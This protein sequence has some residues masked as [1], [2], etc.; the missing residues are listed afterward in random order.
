MRRLRNHWRHHWRFY[1]AALLGAV[2][3]AVL[4]G[5]GFSIRILAAGNSSFALYLLLMAIVVAQTT[6]KDLKQRSALEDEGIAI[7][8]LVALAIIVLSSIAIFTALRQK[9]GPSPLA[10][11]LALAGIPLGWFALHTLIAFH[12]A[13]IYYG[14]NGSQKQ[15]GLDFPQTEEPDVWEFLYYSFTIG[16]TAQTS[17]TN[18]TTTRMRRATLAHS[19]LSFFYNTAIIAMAVNAVVSLAS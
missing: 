2:V 16:T 7:V 1:S 12:Y 4:A 5:Q 11:T 14:K 8:L 13:Y 9:Q 15:G 19:V 17:D 6:A 18:V 3:F 10:L